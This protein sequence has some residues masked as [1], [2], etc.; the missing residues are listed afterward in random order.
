MSVA[1]EWVRRR[2]GAC[3]VFLAVFA[4][5]LSFALYTHHAWEDYYI[6]YRCSKNLA[7]GQGLVFTP[8]E[9][10]HAFTS[11][12]N[13]LLPA[14]LSYMTG[15]RSDRLVLWLF[16][17]ISAGMLA[18][19]AVLLYRI[20][21]AQSLGR[22]ATLTLV[23]LFATL[24][25]VVDFSINGQEIG[26]MMFFLALALESLMV[27]GRRAGLRLGLAWAGLMWT[28]PDSCVYIAI[29]AGAFFVFH[30][31]TAVHPSRWALAR[32]YCVAGLVTGLCYAPWFGWAWWYYGSPVPHT[33]IAKGLQHPPNRAEM[34][35][36][37]ASLFSQL[38]R[39]DTSP[40]NGIFAP[41]YAGFGQWPEWMF[42]GCGLLAW[43]AAVYW[44]LP[45]GRRTTRAV[46][47]AF[48]GGLWYIAAVVP[49]PM[50]WYLP[51]AAIF[52]AC[53]VGL[54]MH[55]L[56][57]V[58]AWIQRQP[59]GSAYAVRIRDWFV[60]RGRVLHAA[61]AVAIPAFSLVLLAMCAFQL[62]I[63][64]RE[65][66]LGNRMQIG[67]WLR[68]HAQSP[69][70]SVFLEPLG[71]IGFY[72]QMKILDWPGLC[73]PEV[74]AAR[75]TQ[76]TW[77]GTVGALMPDWLVLRPEEEGWLRDGNPRLL[78]EHYA[79]ARV[80]DVSERLKAYPWI[81]GRRYPECDQRFTVYRRLDT[82][83]AGQQLAADHRIG[84]R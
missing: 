37:T 21:R 24:P 69:R 35:D 45:F 22:G 79:V 3:L 83:T 57:Q 29:L 23:G 58:L 67:L 62:R 82:R 25:G 64:Q 17:A 6:T 54:V 48:L 74:V 32:T 5:A 43:I 33:I 7:T 77:V 84:G 60:V 19:A 49:S 34:W 63:Q 56:A 78:A 30:A 59:I 75:R 50:P 73:S 68:G 38:L 31:R 15:N 1:R 65:V 39:G 66:E 9:R 11:P 10:V 40:V 53:V 76:R 51:N 14:G 12:L 13:T 28:R 27:P 26:L 55:D 42:T 61:V 20:A 8:G 2:Q 36:A 47:L 16:R 41:P 4:L 18:G 80:F 72:S 44:I 52:G 81:P 71:Y 46:S 70:E